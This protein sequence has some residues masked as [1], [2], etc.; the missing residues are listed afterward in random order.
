M[1]PF[2]IESGVAAPL[3]RS[4]IDTDQITPGRAGMKVQKTGFAEGLFYNWRFAADG[5]ENPDFILNQPPFRAARFLLS[6]ENFGCGSSREFAVWA[7]RDFGVRAVIAPSF[8]AIFTSN[9]FINGVLPIRLTENEISAIVAEISPQHAQITVDLEQS[10]VFSPNGGAFAFHVPALQ[11]EQLLEGLD[12][13]DATR[14][15]EPVIAAFQ[16]R[17]AIKRPWVYAPPLSESH[18]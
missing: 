9:C 4:N 17:D 13:I 5:S 1:N 15:R 14:K 8:G 3:M 18:T 11:R 2:V 10:K 6:G 7:L 16:A 12:A